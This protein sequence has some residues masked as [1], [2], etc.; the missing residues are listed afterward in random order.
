MLVELPGLLAEHGVDAAEIFAG[1]GLGQP[2]RTLDEKL[3]FPRIV[4][5]L[6][7]SA[8]RTRCPHFG[9]LLGQRFQL[10]HH[11]P[12]GE[13]MRHAPTLGH[14]LGD[15]VSWQPGYSSGAIVYLHRLG[16]DHALGY[17]TMGGASRVVHDLVITVGVRM[18][19]QLTHGAVRPEEVHFAH[20][21]PADRS[22]YARYLNVPLRFNEHRVCAVLSGAA[23]GTRLP[24]ADHARHQAI[25][26]KLR[27]TLRVAA[28][29]LSSRTRRILR[30][31]LQHGSPSMDAVAAALAMHPRTLRR[32]LAKEQTSFEILSSATRFDMAKELLHLTD[33][34]VSEIGT[35]LAYASPSVFADAFRRW[36]G[37][38]PTE[39]RRQHGHDAPA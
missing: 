27:D 31:L 35:A 28:T 14:A 13:L 37:L 16:E 26:A 21:P 36:S 15:F 23:L 9:L 38:T 10:A 25:Q 24:D 34:P 39:W 7:N 29:D 5:A 22:A 19:D 32:H 20:R 2:P 8:V 33:L 17:G 4:Q 11:G 12:I 3:S 6:E 1:A 30:N 18:L